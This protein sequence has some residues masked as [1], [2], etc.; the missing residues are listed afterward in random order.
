MK[1]KTLALL[2]LAG[3]SANA[4][5]YKT[6]SDISYTPNND[7]YSHQRCRL[8]IYH[9]ADTA[10]LPV[11][12]WFHGGGLTGG[13]R[14]IPEELK[15]SGYVIVAPN[16]RLIPDAEI[17]DCIADAAAA[18]AWTF[19]N[20][21]RYG[22]DPSKIFVAGHSAGGYLT[23]MIGFDKKWLARHGVSADS[24]KGL[25]PYSGQAITHFALRKSKG[26]SELQPTVDEFAPLFHIRKDA[27]P[28]IIITGDRNDELYGRYEENAYLW[29]LLKLIGHPDVRIYEIE[30]HDHGEMVTPAHHILKD[31]IDRILRKKR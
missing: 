13:K 14:Y 22:G 23:S 12:V 20:I 24:I 30:G 4:T 17:Q 25:I 15:E 27:P 1:I 6:D 29:R 16:Y 3:I 7:S 19:R 11:I 18:V 28:Y 10:D 2:L 31:N 8:D 26:I 5:T 9:P 21:S